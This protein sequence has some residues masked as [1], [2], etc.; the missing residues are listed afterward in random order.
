MINGVAYKYMCRKSKIAQHL[1]D[2]GHTFCLMESNMDTNQYARKGKMLDALEKFH[3]FVQT[4]KGTHI[5]DKLT[6]EN[7]PIFHVLVRHLQRR[8]NP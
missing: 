8:G 1:L 6:V 2:E 5:N 7:N 3:I 4:H